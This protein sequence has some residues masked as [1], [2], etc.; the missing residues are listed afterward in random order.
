MCICM[1]RYVC[2]CYVH[3]IFAA[4][5]VYI[6]VM[7]I[8]YLQSGAYI[9]MHIHS[10]DVVGCLAVMLINIFLCIFVDAYCII[11]EDAR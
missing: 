3:F 7:Y 5:R 10:A 11:V 6:Y 9:R 8:L 1:Y 2:I 4:R